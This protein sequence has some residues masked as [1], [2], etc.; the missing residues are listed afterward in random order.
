MINLP[1][2]VDMARSP[3]ELKE[4]AEDCCISPDSAQPVYPWG[5]CLRFD[6]DS[7]G[8]LGLGGDVQ[9]GDLIMIA[10]MGKVTNVSSNEVARDGKTEINRHVEVQL[11]HISLGDE[12]D[13]D[14]PERKPL[15]ERLYKS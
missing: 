8:K 12:H 9:A 2:F 15:R 7:L 14:V 10:A 4:K 11:T 1:G 13:E 5:L 6:N 3:E